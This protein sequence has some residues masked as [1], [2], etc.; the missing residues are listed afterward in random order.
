MEEIKANVKTKMQK[1]LDSLKSNLSKIR[2]GRAHTGILDHINVDY[3]GALTSLSQVASVTLAD[4]TTI[5]IQPYEKTMIPII[6]KVIRESDLGLNPATSGEV[7]RIPMPPL[8]E[9]RRRELIKVVKSEAENSKVSMRNIR[10][11]ANDALKKLIKDKEISE[12]DERRA[13]D[14]VQKTTDQF[15]NEID[16]LTELKE[17]DLLAI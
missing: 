17:K 12:D 4:S 6:E 16:K 7:I 13:Q 3:Y 5:N 14:E 1:S 10:R 2:T 15:I 8:T 9:E 11:E